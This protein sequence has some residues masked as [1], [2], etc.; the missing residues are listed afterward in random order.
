[1]DSIGALTIV[2]LSVLAYFLP[3]VVATTRTPRKRAGPMVVNLFLGWTFLGWVAALA[4][5]VSLDR[6]Q[7]RQELA[8]ARL[9]TRAT[10]LAWAVLYVLIA[11]MIEFSPAGRAQ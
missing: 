7:G 1:M 8:D 9:A 6:P 4:W 11:L 3:T 5:A 10:L 2:A